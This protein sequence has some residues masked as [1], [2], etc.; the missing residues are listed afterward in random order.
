MATTLSF[1]HSQA[2][3]P[4]IPV[5]DFIVQAEACERLADALA[6]SADPLHSKALCDRLHAS[7]LQLEPTLLEPIPE[8]LADGFT[9]NTFPIDIPRFEPD[10]TD[11]C[12]YCL[13]LTALLSGRESVP[14][15]GN[16]LRD[17]LCELTRYF[18]DEMEAPRWV[19]MGDCVVSR[20]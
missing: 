3:T 6:E 9:A 12:R 16:V 10:C 7:L 2:G 19:R 13:T 5:P 4:F 15:A 20:G 11:L 18:V 17:L 8:H 1:F 14:E